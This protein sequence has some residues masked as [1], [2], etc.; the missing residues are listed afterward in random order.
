MTAQIQQATA[1][2]GHTKQYFTFMLA[3]E[4]YGFDILSVLEIRGLEHMTS[5]PSAPHYIKGVVNLRGTIIPAMDLRERF[6]IVSIP[7]N[8]STVMIVVQITNNEKKRIVGI[9]VDSVSDVYSIN[10]Q[11]IQP[12]PEIYEN[13]RN[14]YISGLV[15]IHQNNEEDKL[16][17]ILD[18][19]KLFD[20]N[21]LDS[22]SI[23][24]KHDDEKN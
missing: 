24:N 7:Y 5:L 17:I 16:L 6:N 4:E 1:D 21:E 18:V 19:N 20:V 9:I 8:R 12:K 10:Q 13:A 15:T 22:L 2:L 23:R 14:E 11:E 3:D